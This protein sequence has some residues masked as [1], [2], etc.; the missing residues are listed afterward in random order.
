MSEVW[1]VCPRTRSSEEKQEFEGGEEEA[2]TQEDQIKVGPERE[3]EES[4]LG[5]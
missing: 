4:V 5:R 1:S 3:E 2:Q